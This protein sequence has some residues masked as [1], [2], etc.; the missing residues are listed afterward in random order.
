LRPRGKR[1][2]DI[3]CALLRGWAEKALRSGRT[4]HERDEF[5]SC[6]LI[7]F[8]SALTRS[9]GLSLHLAGCEV[10]DIPADW[11]F[12]ELWPWKET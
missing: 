1:P 7:A 5:T 4:A 9:P 2:A 8:A 3:R 11:A 6:Q 12:V 10:A